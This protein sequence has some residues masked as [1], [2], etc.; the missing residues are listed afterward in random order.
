MASNSPASSFGSNASSPTKSSQC[1]H[2]ISGVVR[3]GSV[4]ARISAIQAN[5]SPE[6]KVSVTQSPIKPPV[7]SGYVLSKRAT[8]NA[9]L[10]HAKNIPLP[11]SPKKTQINLQSSKDKSSPTSI[12]RNDEKVK[13]KS[14]KYINVHHASG[15]KSYE[16]TLPSKNR[17]ENESHERNLLD[18]SI[19][20][21][22]RLPLQS[23]DMHKANC[24]AKRHPPERDLSTEHI[25]P[26]S[27][28]TILAPDEVKDARCIPRITTDPSKY[29]SPRTATVVESMLE[30]NRKVIR[31]SGSA[32]SRIAPFMMSPSVEYVP[33]RQSQ[34][35]SPLDLRSISF[36]RKGSDIQIDNDQVSP[37]PPPSS[38][39]FDRGGRRS[40]RRR[41]L[42]TYED[43]GA[44][45]KEISQPTHWRKSST[46]LLSSNEDDVFVNESRVPKAY[47]IEAP[48]I[49]TNQSIVFQ[50]NQQD[51]N[52]A[53]SLNYK[54]SIMPRDGRRHSNAVLERAMSDNAISLPQHGPRH[55]SDKS[56]QLNRVNSVLSFLDEPMNTAS[57]ALSPVDVTCDAH[58]S[59]SSESISPL[60][61][62]QFG[63]DATIC[64]GSQISSYSH[65]AAGATSVP[66]G[67][68]NADLGTNPETNQMVPQIEGQGP[69]T[70]TRVRTGTVTNKANLDGA[71]GLCGRSYSMSGDYRAINVRVETPKASSAT[72]IPRVSNTPRAMS[73]PKHV[74]RKP[75]VTFE[76]EDTHIE[77]DKL[78]TT[79]EKGLKVIVTM[80]QD[81]EEMI[82]IEVHPSPKHESSGCP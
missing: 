36:E 61:A 34:S 27:A 50:S 18:E 77:M 6:K 58:S 41:T 4:A 67:E 37:P 14:L 16:G 12:D 81:I 23:Q 42:A 55:S 80:G 25:L 76:S 72:R 68:G 5:F 69:Q 8:F 2:A 19:G 9:Y 24:S 11:E 39:L 49:A 38:P 66:S 33:R 71:P 30:G 46:L 59:V 79:R 47:Q 29:M 45:E 10:E 32:Y 51:T 62:K 74:R 26:A 53:H 78:H 3:E 7:S 40:L 1:P 22:H 21:E 13:I 52:D 56:C 48:V 20:E 44:S 17:Y 57:R 43:Q 82:K 28:E 65:M 70:P 73:S 75:S 64:A 63:E 31:S 60:L 15:N 35:Q 54:P